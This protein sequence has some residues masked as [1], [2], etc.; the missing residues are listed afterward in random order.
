[1][2]SVPRSPEPAFLA[3][4]RAAHPQWTDLNAANRQAVR[5]ALRADFHQCCAYCEN[6]CHIAGNDA[7]LETVDHFRPRSKFPR[8]ALDWLNLV[9]A[10]QRCNT[11]KGN[12]W[13]EQSDAVNQR[14]AVVAGFTPVTAYVNPNSISHQRPAHEFF[15]F[16]LFGDNGGQIVPAAPLSPAER[17]TAQ[18]TIEDLDL[19]DDYGGI[20]N[21]LPELRTERLDF[22]L[23]EIGDPAA[24]LPRTESIL[25]AYSR[26][27]QPFSS[28][29]ATYALLLGI[30]DL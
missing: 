30:V 15:E 6:R 21:R 4:I 14:Y 23:D 10:C 11:T 27:D 28:Y 13:P 26:P 3:A 24:D 7:S 29:V 9:Y 5:E 2:H 12:L 18:R 1:M 19:N 22:I 25:R 16:Y 8:Q 20:N 17:L